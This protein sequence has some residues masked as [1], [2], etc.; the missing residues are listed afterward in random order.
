MMEKGLFR[1]DLFYRLN[2][3]P[4]RIPPLR[5]RVDEIPVLALG[6]LNHSARH[7]GGSSN[8]RLEPAALDLLLNYTWPGNIRELENAMLRAS[9]LVDDGGSVGP[10]LI[11]ES[12]A[13]DDS[14]PSAGVAPHEIVPLRVMERNAI[15]AALEA[16]GG[17][18]SEAAHKLGIGEKTIYNKIK[19]YGLGTQRQSRKGGSA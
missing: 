13:P 9:T 10:D 2:V 8:L 6:F 12:P 15:A 1:E 11:V 4:V 5:E 19:K 3:C 7:M 16:C 14:A 17:N 18:R